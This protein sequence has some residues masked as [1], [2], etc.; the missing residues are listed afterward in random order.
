[1]ISSSMNPTRRDRSLRWTSI[2]PVDVGLDSKVESIL[3]VMVAAAERR[4]VAMW[5]LKEM[6]RCV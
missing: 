6:N 5:K 1:M 3:D 4:W 2:S